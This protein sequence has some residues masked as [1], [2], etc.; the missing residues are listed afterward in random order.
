[1]DEVSGTF[2]SVRPGESASGAV[3]LEP[4]KYYYV[5]S[6][7]GTIGKKYSF[8][9]APAGVTSTYEPFALACMAAH[10]PVVKA[11]EELTKAKRKLDKARARHRKRAKIRALQ[12]LV[13]GARTAFNAAADAESAACSVPQ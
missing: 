6:C 13:K 5:M 12:N 7:P 4:G 11:A 10:P 1:M 8:S 3:T 2:L 9:L